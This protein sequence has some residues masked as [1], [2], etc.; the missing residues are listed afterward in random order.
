MRTNPTVEEFIAKHPVETRAIIERLRR[1]VKAAMPEAK[2]TV[3]HESLGYS[4]TATPSEMSVYV[5]PTK[6]YVTLGFFFGAHFP[7]PL[8]LLTGEGSRMRHVKVKSP[9]EAENPALRS[10]VEA[11]VLDAPKS[12]ASIHRT[13]RFP[14]RS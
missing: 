2:E 9:D 3:Y 13:Q 4:F 6:N 11:A 10:L 8:H 12:Y 1:M 7:D 14:E 5:R